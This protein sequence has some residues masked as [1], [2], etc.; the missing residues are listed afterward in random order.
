[1]RQNILIKYLKNKKKKIEKLKE[2]EK[3]ENFKRKN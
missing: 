1:M 2:N 3:V